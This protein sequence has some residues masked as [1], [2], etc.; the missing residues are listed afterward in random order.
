MRIDDPDQ[1]VLVQ[2]STVMVDEHM[3]RNQFRFHAG[4]PFEV[5]ERF[6]DARLGLAA[7]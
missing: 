3:I 4:D 7:G 6:D 5:F 2:L 1:L